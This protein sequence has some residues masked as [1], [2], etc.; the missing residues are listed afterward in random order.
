MIL[1]RDRS[2]ACACAV[3]HPPTRGEDEEQ[4]MQ[5][6]TVRLTDKSVQ[7]LQDTA[8][9]TE[10]SRTDVINRALQVYQVVAEHVAKGAD[11][12]FAYPNGG[13]V[14]IRNADLARGT[15]LGS[16]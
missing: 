13:F 9:L 5:D 10:L 16:A 14:L 4:V 11:L 8:A 12:R 7:A 1:L 15:E 3:P 6:C 2:C